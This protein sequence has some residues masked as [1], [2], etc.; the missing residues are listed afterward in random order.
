MLTKI[1]NWNDLKN[2]FGLINTTKGL[3]SAK[4]IS[5]ELSKIVKLSGANKGIAIECNTDSEAVCLFTLLQVSNN[6]FIDTAEYEY[7]GTAN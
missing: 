7:T 6:G 2:Q 3:K 4:Q 1:T 5:S